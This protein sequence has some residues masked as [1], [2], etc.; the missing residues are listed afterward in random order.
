M[1]LVLLI[2]IQAAGKTTFCQ[3]FLGST[4]IRVNL[5]TIKRRSVEARVVRECIA[6][7][8]PIVVDNT[9]VLAFDRARYIPLAKAAGYRVKGYVFQ[10]PVE[11]AITRNSGRPG[12]ACVPS[13]VIHATMAKFEQPAWSEGFDELYRVTVGNDFVV[14]R[15]RRMRRSAHG[16]F[17]ASPTC[18]QRL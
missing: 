9:N 16:A 13:H 4:H 11:D 1:E 8:Q 12:K 17:Q 5:D 7:K 6:D 2:G 18:N 14:K 10:C 15:M 3:R